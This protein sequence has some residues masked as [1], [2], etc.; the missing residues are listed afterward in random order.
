MY[1]ASIARRTHKIDFLSCL[2]HSARQFVIRRPGNRTEVISGYPWHGVAG[3]QTFVSL[4]GITLQ[5]NH[6]EDCIDVL[7]TEVRA[8]K[9]G[10]FSGSSSAAEAVDA[11]LWFFWTLQRLGEQIG[12]A[13]IWKR[14]GNV[15]KQLLESYRRGIA[16]RVALHDNG[17][18][19]AASDEVPLTWMNS[20]INGRAVTPRNGYQ[21]EVNALWYNAV[22]YALELAREQGDRAFVQE[23]EMLP[24]RIS[25]A[26]NETFVLPEGYLADYVDEQGANR[27]IRPNM[28]LAC[29]LPYK[30]IDEQT[31]LG[32]I[33]TVRQHLLTPKGLRTLSPRN[34]LYR[35]SQEGSPD[36][37]DFAA[38]NGSVWPWLL[39][40]YVKACFDI[41]GE[42]FV[43]QAEELLAS[44]EEDIQ[45]Y[46]I[47]S[48][49]EL[50][51]ADPPYASRGAISQAWSVGAV[52]DIYHLIRAYRTDAEETPAKKAPAKKASA[53]AATTKKATEKTAAKAAPAKRAAKTAKKEE[54]AE[55]PATKTRKT[56]KKTTK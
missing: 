13:E 38:K 12:G 51:D 56:T 19:W 27:F 50:Y 53:K 45:T 20:T 30:P 32:V 26:F 14:Y 46:C 11:P 17:L 37:R 39:S 3:R 40:F 22:C 41:D 2:E 7:D 54:T 6:K 55:A 15:M 24:P 25:A 42:A 16:G 9:E 52:L 5:Q 21:V 48:I 36:E 10:M 28:I 8:M 4:P 49:C 34:P 29:S 18:L 43:P 35:G 47:G 44:F 33:R 31:R 1:N 23:W